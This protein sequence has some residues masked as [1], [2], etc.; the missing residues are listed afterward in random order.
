MYQKYYELLLLYMNM[1]LYLDFLSFFFLFCSLPKYDIFFFLPV[2]PLPRAMTPQSEV[3]Y[4]LAQIGDRVQE[5]YSSQ[6]C[7]TTGRILELPRPQVTY[8]VFQ[9]IAE[10]LI[11]ASSG[12]TRV[13]HF[14]DSLT[15]LGPNIHLEV[16]YNS[17]SSNTNMLLFQI[18]I[19]IQLQISNTTQ[20]STITFCIHWPGGPVDFKSYWPAKKV[21]GPNFFCRNTH[22][23]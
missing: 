7:E 1:L 6:L 3:A 19:Q 21:T 2:M 9:Q 14:L 10:E 18:S 22:L 20:G 11:S 5:E 13:R 12:W 8:C 15:G 16:K 4:Y 17:A 23:F